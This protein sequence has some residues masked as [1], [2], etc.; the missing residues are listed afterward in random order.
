MRCLKT[1]QG[2][3]IACLAT[4]PSFSP[5]QADVARAKGFTLFGCNNVWKD[6]PDLALLYACNEGWWNH[7]WSDELAKYPAQKW[8][9]NKVAAQKYGLNW[10]DEKDAP[11]LS[12]DPECIHHGHGSGFTMVNLAFL[13]GA[14]RIVLLGYDLKY[15]ADYKGQDRNP[16]STPRHY[17]AGGEYPSALRHWPFWSIERGVHVEMLKIYQ[18]VADQGLVEIVNCSPGSALECFPKM[19]IEDVL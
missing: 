6:V 8:T 11:G 7:Y 10:I 9:T 5:Q 2:H 1:F 4:G 14:S 16:G 12:A 17:F 15:A 3:T 13:M 18:S 19:R